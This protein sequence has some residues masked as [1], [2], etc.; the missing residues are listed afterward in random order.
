[1]TAEWRSVGVKN[2]D[3]GTVFNLSK[4]RGDSYTHVKMQLLSITLKETSVAMPD[5]WEITLKDDIP[6]AMSM[7]SVDIEGTEWPFEQATVKSEAGIQ[8]IYQ[9]V[10]PKPDETR[11]APVKMYAKYESTRDDQPRMINGSMIILPHPEIEKPKKKEGG[12][13]VVQ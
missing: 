2:L 4:G 9:V 3:K 1:M 12:C 10:Y 13:C 8:R 11:N 5:G 7:A 6:K